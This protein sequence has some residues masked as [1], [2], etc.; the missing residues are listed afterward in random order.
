MKGQ[1]RLFYPLKYV[2]ILILKAVLCS[3][4]SVFF[5]KTIIP[6]EFECL[7]A[8]APPARTFVMSLRLFE[9]EGAKYPGLICGGHDC[10]IHIL[11]ATE[12]GQYYPVTV[13]N[14][15]EDW[16][17]TLDIMKEG[18]KGNVVR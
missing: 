13:L 18:K 17:T 16:V 2:F 14:G 12:L 11:T 15:H 6:G 3:I 1:K 4:R 5:I 10:R 8:F 9:V 7:N